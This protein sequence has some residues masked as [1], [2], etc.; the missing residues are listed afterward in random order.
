MREVESVRHG[1]TLRLQITG[2]GL[3]LGL[4]L[5]SRGRAMVVFIIAWSS[6]WAG[7][8][9]D[10]ILKL[11]LAGEIAQNLTINGVILIFKYGILIKLWHQIIFSLRATPQFEER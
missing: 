11:I 3:A 8:T 7:A 5:M 1:A 6:D 4:D 2:P 10:T 9:L